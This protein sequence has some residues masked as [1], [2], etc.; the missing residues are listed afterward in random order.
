[1]PCFAPDVVDHERPALPLEWEEAVPSARGVDPR[2][3][4]AAP[5]WDLDDGVLVDVRA[6]EQAEVAAAGGWRMR[7][8]GGV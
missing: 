3:E 6:L 5:A 1:M 7:G 2:N 4:V 8:G